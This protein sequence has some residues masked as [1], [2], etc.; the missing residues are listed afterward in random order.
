MNPDSAALGNPSFRIGDVVVVGHLLPDGTPTFPADQIM[1][2][3]NLA[4]R[5]DALAQLDLSELQRLEDWIH[6]ALAARA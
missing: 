5:P 4:S 6:A 2:I 1:A 3:F